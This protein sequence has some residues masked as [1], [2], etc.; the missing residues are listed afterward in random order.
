M[1]A[2]SGS[3]RLEVAGG[4]SS[5]AR[6]LALLLPA[7]RARFV[8]PGARTLLY[9]F[10]IDTEAGARLAPGGPV[11]PRLG[12]RALRAGLPDTSLLF[13]GSADSDHADAVRRAMA[14]VSVDLRPAGRGLDPRI[15][16]TVRRMREACPETVPATVLAEAEGLSAGRLMHL[17]KQQTG[18]PLRRF[19]L[20]LKTRRALWLAARSTSIT[21]VAPMAG[22][23]DAAHLSRTI[24]DMFGLWPSYFSRRRRVVMHLRDSEEAAGRAIGADLVEP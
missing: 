15:A 17:F 5:D 20:W 6:T 7:T 4:R 2:L 9:I 12:D 19:A 10:D 18:V 16:A 14:E 22:F 23:A 8:G 11:L 3:F 21:S 24:H 13:D 1:L